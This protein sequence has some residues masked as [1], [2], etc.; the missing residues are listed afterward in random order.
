MWI[1]KSTLRGD[2]WSEKR[3]FAPGLCP[4]TDTLRHRKK[5]TG[6]LVCT[7]RHVR[8]LFITLSCVRLFVSQTCTFVWSEWTHIYCEWCA[9]SRT[10]MHNQSNVLICSLAL[11]L[12]MHVFFI[13]WNLELSYMLFLVCCLDWL[14]HWLF[15]VSLKLSR[16]HPVLQSTYCGFIQ[17]LISLWWGFNNYCLSIYNHSGSFLCVHSNGNGETQQVKILYHHF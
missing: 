14:K 11:L 6:F 1:C 9:E 15:S 3:H 7:T 5:G 10:V 4:C 17:K 16:P 8:R 12:N 13:H 2:Y